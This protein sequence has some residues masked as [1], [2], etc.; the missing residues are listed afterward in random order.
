MNIDEFN[1]LSLNDAVKTLKQLVHIDR[2]A[3]EL[4]SQ[5]PFSNK[6]DLISAAKLQCPTWSWTE[7]VAALATHPRIGEKKAELEL[8]EGEKA[9]SQSEQSTLQ[10]DSNSSIKKA[11]L[12]GNLDYEKKFDFIYLV[13][14]MGRSSEEILSI[15]EARLGNDLDTEKTIVHQNLCEIAL[16]RLENIIQ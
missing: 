4:A 6:N 12:K 15:L 14:A 1:A 7:I 11:L 5:R 9:F 10:N 3:I 13:R 8:S 2:W 16:L